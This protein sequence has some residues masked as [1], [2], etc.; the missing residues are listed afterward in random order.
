MRKC[1]AL[2]LCIMCIA[3]MMPAAGA[4]T[5]D[6]TLEVSLYGMTLLPSGEWKS[7][8]LSGAFSVYQNG[9][10]VGKLTVNSFGS[11]R[12]TLASGDEVTLIPEAGSMPK[13]YRVEED[14]YTLSITGGIRNTAHI[15]AYS[16]SGLFTV[17]ADGEKEFTVTRAGEEEAYFYFVNDAFSL[18]FKTSKD[19][20]YSLQE[21]IPV[22]D[23][24]LTDVENGNTIEF[25]IASYRG[26]PRDITVID[27]RADAA[28]AVITAVPEIKETE[29]PTAAPT[30]I[31]T[32]E[33]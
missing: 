33:P 25:S 13:G 29:A 12:L 30:E 21:P 4:E 1:V 14:G 26:N 18:R 32:E 20:V 22:D 7:E 15:I 24:V 8:A 16:D 23:Y 9:A 31:P 17:Y 5:A 11:T 10:N 2:L 6:T 28:Q 19:G 27:T 3:M